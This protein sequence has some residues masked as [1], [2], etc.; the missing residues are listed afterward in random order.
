MLNELKTMLDGLEQVTDIDQT[1]K[2][3]TKAGGKES[4]RVILDVDVTDSARIE[5]LEYMNETHLNNV[6][7]LRTSNQDQFPAIKLTKPLRPSGNKFYNLVIAYR[8]EKKPETKREIINKLN[9]LCEQIGF[10]APELTLYEQLPLLSSLLIQNFPSEPLNESEWPKESYR[11]KIL[12]RHKQLA[13]SENDQIRVVAELYNRYSKL[14]KNGIDFLFQLDEKIEHAL[15]NDSLSES[16]ILL[17]LNALF[18]GSEL[19]SSGEI[20]ENRVQLILDYLPNENIDIFATNLEKNKIHLSDYLIAQESRVGTSLRAHDCPIIG[21]SSSLITDKFPSLNLGK[22]KPVSQITPYSKFDAGGGK[23]TVQRYKKSGVDSF[24][25]DK[26]LSQKF[27]GLFQKL[28]AEKMKDQTWKAIPSEKSGQR[29]LLIAYCRGDLSLPATQFV[30][31]VEDMDD[32][33]SRTQDLISL[34]NKG[35]LSPDAL[36]DFVV[37]RKVDKANQKVVYSNACSLRQLEKSAQSWQIACANIPDFTLAIIGK[38]KKRL[39][40]KPYAI[41]PDQL[42]ALSRQVF[43]SNGDVSKGEV[44]AISFNEAMRIFFSQ[45]DISQKIAE[46]SLKK[47]TAQT[48]RLFALCAEVK[49]MGSKEKVPIDANSYALKMTTLMAVLL[50]KMNRRK[51]DY[52]RELSF[53]LGQYCS[54]MNELHVGYCRVVR[55]GSMPTTL[56]GS[57]AYSIALHSPIRAL[58]YIALRLKPYEGWARDMQA[59]GK[60]DNSLYAFHWMQRNAKDLKDALLQSNS[61]DSKNHQAEL[62]LGYLAGRPF[63]KSDNQSNSTEEGNK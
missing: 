38:D 55:K 48:Q 28:T 15:L 39:Y 29:D 52:M 22:G 44:P 46:H 3:I 57:A 53:K 7:V 11:N 10:Q 30:T 43:D 20:K 12:E 9:L 50:F 58:E 34:F 4:I 17:L 59:E 45:D 51:E 16:M 37:I 21:S 31:Q 56:I 47:I 2:D 54:A 36:V 41:A 13:A 35:N 6:W 26:E 27:D 25:I 63:E 19:K 14:G 32:Y 33:Q 1:H 5:R 42:T 40:V 8:K 18:G 49:N 60:Q 61:N 24:T 23:L 62:M